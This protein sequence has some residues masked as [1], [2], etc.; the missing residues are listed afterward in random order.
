M[1]TLTED[2][3]ETKRP[4]TASTFNLWA[5]VY[6][7]QSNPF[8]S[9]EE[10][11]ISALLPN[12][13][14]LEVLD[15]GCG[16][17]RMLALLKT[18]NARSVIGVDSSHAMLDRARLVHGIEARFGSCT[19]LPLADATVDCAISS[20]VLSYISDLEAFAD[21]VRRVTRPGA[22]VLLSDIHPDT[23]RTLDWKRSFRWSG[24]KIEVRSEGWHIDEIRAAFVAR[25]FSIRVCIEPRFSSPEQ[26][27]FEEA[28]K[29]KSFATTQNFPAIYVLELVRQTTPSTPTLF[30][31][32]NARCALTPFDAAAAT[33]TTCGN[34]MEQVDSR[35]F[36]QSPELSTL[37]LSGY[38][39]LPGLINA[40]DHLEFALFPRLG[41]GRYANAAQW[42]EDIHR[43]DAATIALHRSIPRDVRIAWGAIRNL[44]AG[45]TTVCHHNPLT[46]EML[47]PDFPVSVLRN[48]QW[49]HSLAVDG[50]LAT[51]RE[52]NDGVVPFIVHAAEGIDEASAREFQ[53]LLAQGAVHQ[54]T[55]LIHGLAIP[56]ESIAKMNDC[57]GALVTCPSSNEFLFG[58][59][60]A[61]EFL[62]GIDKLA[63]GSDSPLTAT[64]DLLDE[65]RFARDRV[66]LPEEELYRMV[67]SAPAQIL[68]LKHGE[69]SITPRS[70]ADFI[71]TKDRGLS[72]S[73]TLADM[74]SKDVELVVRAGRIFLVSD[75][76]FERLPASQRTGLE[77][78]IVDGE[79]RW[80][81]TPL[82]HLFREAAPVMDGDTLLLGGKKVT[83]GNAA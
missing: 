36:E 7:A 41:R 22:V 44:L 64:G 67:T 77:P 62:L 61:P 23:A 48:F 68:Q 65:L 27:I 12:L 40:H 30:A 81:R 43:E 79:R 3:R 69:G 29:A 1:S 28:R 54:N 37:N 47:D 21:E 15:A 25:G 59:V 26:D 45:V 10:R 78:L 19:A 56:P 50:I 80:I 24:Q 52:A 31:Y 72:P 51:G 5:E 32:T 70:V 53:Q 14:G 49:A 58:C 73:A 34:R 63:L 20:F 17:G 13:D 2:A 8:L 42:A 71:A 55:V 33:L 11:V 39:I 18:R 83:Y 66:G 16:T 4:A 60:P 38:H 82:A 6:D 35:A 74:S 76:I 57:R 46:P 9:L 75:A